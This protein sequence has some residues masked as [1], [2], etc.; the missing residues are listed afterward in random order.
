VCE[1]THST[2]VVGDFLQF[3]LFCTQSLL[4]FVVN[5]LRLVCVL[6]CRALAEISD[7]DSSVIEPSGVSIRKRASTAGPVFLVAAHQSVPFSAQA[8]LRSS[9]ILELSKAS[10]ST[11]HHLLNRFSDSP[12]AIKHT[13]QAGDACVG[14]YFN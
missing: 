12:T 13:E 1:R 8:L 10:K 7:E 14:N 3:V 5:A 11:P 9:G 2:A 6:C 4:C